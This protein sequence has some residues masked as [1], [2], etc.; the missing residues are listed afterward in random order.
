M[1]LAKALLSLVSVFVCLLAALVMCGAL[2]STP[3][4]VIGALV[5]GDNR[6]ARS[7]LVRHP[8]LGW[9]LWLTAAAAGALSMVLFQTTWP[10]G[11]AIITSAAIAFSVVALIALQW[12]AFYLGFGVRLRHRARRA[13][14]RQNASEALA[15]GHTETDEDPAGEAFEDNGSDATAPIIIPGRAGNGEDTTTQE[16]PVLASVAPSD[17]EYPSARPA[18]D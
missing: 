9:F 12:T 7:A 10:T 5:S 13:L 2:V 17:E 14:A 8:R 11:D 6:S 3:G 18:E 15:I 4:F 1:E 16:I